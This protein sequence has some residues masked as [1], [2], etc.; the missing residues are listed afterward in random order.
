MTDVSAAGK[1]VS[2]LLRGGIVRQLSQAGGEGSAGL[3]Y[4]EQSGSSIIKGGTDAN[5]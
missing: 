2:N 4:P 5:N 3:R 1:G